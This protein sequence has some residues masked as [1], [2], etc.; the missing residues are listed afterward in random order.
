[1]FEHDVHSADHF[2]EEQ[3]FACNVEDGVL[4]LPQLKGGEGRGRYGDSFGVGTE[5]LVRGGGG[6]G[7]LVLMERGGFGVVVD[8]AG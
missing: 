8:C 3:S 4:F 5:G 6:G 7:L 2:C 1:L